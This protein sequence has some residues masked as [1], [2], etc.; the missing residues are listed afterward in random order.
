MPERHHSRRGLLALG[1]AA[2]AGT[3]ATTALTGCQHD[4]HTA[5]P[6]DR[7]EFYGTHQA[8]IATP[9]QD[10]LAFAAY[11]LT[12]S[13]SV[14]EKRAAL[15][16]LLKTWTAAAAAM[17]RGRTVPGDNTNLDAPPADTGEAY[18]LSPAN[19]TITFGL[20][21]SLFDD[22]FGLADRRPAALA[23]LPHLPPAD[24]DPARSDGDL[25]IQACADDPLVAFHAIRN[26][27]RIGRDTVVMRWSQLGF[28]KAASNGGDQQ[29]P[30]NLMGFKDGTRNIH[31]DDTDLMD[32]HVWVG[33]ETDQAWMRGGSYL[34]AR[35]IQMR[36]EGWDRDYLADQQN[37]FGRHKYSG[38]P[39]TGSEEHDTPDF[40]AKGADGQPV[41]PAK[42]HIRLAAHENNGGIRILRRGYSFTDG[43]VAA[44]GEL[45]AGL[46]FIAFQ[47]DPRKQFVALQRR[48]GMNDALNE[49]IQHVGSGLFACPPGVTGPGRSWAE[50]L[51]A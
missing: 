42:A 34:V 7:V 22:R 24:L 45:D 10:R 23:D 16:A 21:A 50:Q 3:A 6:A 8:G 40:E 28:G 35:R 4:S 1:G 47:Q 25:A 20:G 51:L 38:A 12:V 46:F 30:R 2:L 15:R 5:A 31:G 37:V 49:Y 13:G 36:I 48:L 32:H 26:L 27:A 9:A 43:I 17:T 14:Q 29:T 33:K 18:G 41:I 44:S 19:L 39:L 11:D